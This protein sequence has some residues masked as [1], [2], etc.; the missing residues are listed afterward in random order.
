MKAL[1]F[2]IIGAQKCA[3]TTLFEHLRA[4]PGIAMPLEKEVPFFTREQCS[5]GDWKEFA[6]QHFTGCD[7]RLWGKA[8]PQYMCDPAAAARIYQLMPDTK[9]I[10]ILRDPVERT[11]S[12][13]QMGRRRATEHRAFDDAVKDLLVPEQV[14]RGRSLPVPRHEAGFEAESDFYVSW[15]EYGRV[16]SAYAELFGEQQLLVLYT[17][18]LESDPAGTLDRILAFIGLDTGFRPPTLGQVIH[19]GGGSNKIPHGLRVWLRE[20]QWLYRL[21]KLLPPAQQGAL[22]FRYEQW[23]VRKQQAGANPIS[24][25]ARAALTAHFA[26][27]LA[28]LLNLPVDAPPWARNYLDLSQFATNG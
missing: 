14:A 13:Y 24:P 23:N 5:P 16:L 26:T 17:E 27:D 7:K 4:H 8:T 6:S 1:D 28:C 20:R 22:R 19:K 11:W 15:S 18:E 3:T 21:W 9:L 10:A 25:E 12:H 2:L